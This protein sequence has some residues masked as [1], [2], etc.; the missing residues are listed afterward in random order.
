MLQ[1]RCAREGPVILSLLAECLRILDGD[2]IPAFNSSQYAMCAIVNR[3]H[4]SG[5]FKIQR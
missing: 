4:T 5:L 1:S 3:T 2:I